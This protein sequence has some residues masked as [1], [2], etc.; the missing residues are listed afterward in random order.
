MES[1][2]STSGLAADRRA[3]FIEKFADYLVSTFDPAKLEK[4]KHRD[5]WLT[6]CMRWLP[7]KIASE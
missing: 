5:G 3:Y 6:S 2:A 4:A 1:Y 7:L